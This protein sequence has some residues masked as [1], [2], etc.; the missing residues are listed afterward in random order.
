[1]IGDVLISTIICENIKRNLPDVEIHYLIN[2]HTVPVVIN[3]PFIDQVVLF[4]ADYKKNKLAFYQFLKDIKEEKY[5]VV[6][7]VY[8]KL[9]SNL[10]SLFSQ[11]PLKA[12]LK[13]WYSSFIYTHHVYKPKNRKRGT[14]MAIEDRLLFLAPILPNLN[15]AVKRPKIYLTEDETCAART[16]LGAHNITGSEPIIML[17]ILGSHPNKTYPLPY[18]AEVI[19]LIAKITDAT[20]LFNY[21]PCQHKQALELYDLC[22]DTTKKQIKI[23]AFA[24][25]LRL[26]LALVHHCNAVIGN[27]GGAINMAKALGVPTFSIFSPWITKAAWDTFSDAS[28]VAVH[29][30]DYRPEE[31]YGKSK[32]ELK[33]NNL[34]LYKRFTPAYFMLLLTDFLKD[35]SVIPKVNP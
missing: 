19:D 3:N 10:I 5:H 30:N 9:E 17:N 8:C 16:F 33:K 4:K 25:S 35:I 18:M 31:M 20:L 32:K 22:N 6:L 12:S 14:G 27:E 11:A 15:E 2:C 34:D 24:S 23:D 1:M 26:F 29:L 21:I 13:K 7:D 28:N